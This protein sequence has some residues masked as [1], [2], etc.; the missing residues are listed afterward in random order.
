MLHYREEKS[1]Y[2]VFGSSSDANKGKSLYISDF[3]ILGMFG[4]DTQ[5]KRYSEE[6]CD[7]LSVDVRRFIA[8]LACGT[9]QSTR[10]TTTCL[11]ASERG[12][13]TPCLPRLP[14]S[15]ACAFQS[16][17][18]AADESSRAFKTHR[19]VADYQSFVDFQDEMTNHFRERRCSVSSASLSQSR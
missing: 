12:R 7:C 3:P 10:S 11:H 4:T 16:T 9:A 17:A 15:Q 5:E 1:A 8:L 2:E 18:D 13:C 19:Y 6:N 14:S